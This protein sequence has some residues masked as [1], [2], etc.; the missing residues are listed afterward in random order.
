MSCGA[1]VSG[2]Y[3]YYRVTCTWALALPGTHAVVHTT[4]PGTHAAFYQVIVVPSN[5]SD[6]CPPACS[7]TSDVLT[8]FAFELRIP[9]PATAPLPKAHL[10]ATCCNMLQHVVAVCL[11]SAWLSV[12]SV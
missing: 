6:K 10:D 8:L 9:L 12:S 1:E 11:R 4:V 7:V 3:R 5:N 2:N